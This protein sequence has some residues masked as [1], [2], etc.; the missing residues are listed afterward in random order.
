MTLFQEKSMHG[1]L[2]LS[3]GDVAVFCVRPPGAD[4]D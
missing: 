1:C 3:I 2:G 4:A